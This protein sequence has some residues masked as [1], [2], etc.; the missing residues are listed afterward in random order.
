MPAQLKSS[1]ASLDAPASAISEIGNVANKI[2]VQLFTTPSVSALW[3]RAVSSCSASQIKSCWS[4]WHAAA[5]SPQQ[6]T[7]EDADHAEPISSAQIRPT[8]RLEDAISDAW[9]EGE[10]LKASRAR[11]VADFKLAH[12]TC[13][14]TK[15]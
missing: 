15:A 3:P 11:E 10:D 5:V 12:V 13:P 4:C 6:A 9:A 7:S 1:L 14:F 8:R 2:V